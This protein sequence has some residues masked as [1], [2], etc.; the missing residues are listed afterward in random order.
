MKKRFTNILLLIMLILISL[1]FSSCSNT[2]NTKKNEVITETEEVYIEPK[3]SLKKL[4][5]DATNKSL[6]GKILFSKDSNETISLCIANLNNNSLLEISSLP[7]KEFENSSLLNL[8][9]ISPDGTKVVFTF[10]NGKDKDIFVIDTDGKNLINLSND[11]SFN[12][13][14]PEFSPD[15]KRVVFINNINN[16]REIFL[17]DTNGI[18]LINLSNSPESDDYYPMFSLDCKKLF[19]LSN[20]DGNIEIYSVNTDGATLRNLTKDQGDERFFELSP[21]GKLIAYSSVENEKVKICFINTDGSGKKII[22]DNLIECGTLTWSPNGEKLAIV[23]KIE[24]PSLGTYSDLNDIFL[25]DKDGKNFHNFTN[26]PMHKEFFGYW[27]P[28][29]SKFTFSQYESDLWV[30]SK[31]FIVDV[32]TENYKAIEFPRAWKEKGKFSLDSKK[33][34]YEICIERGTWDLCLANDEGK[35]LKRL[36]ETKPDEGLGVGN[37]EWFNNSNWVAYAYHIETIPPMPSNSK[38]FVE[39]IDS[40]EKIEIPEASEIIDVIY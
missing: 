20:R 37:Y 3:V 21:D 1:C 30:D 29:S 23:G 5:I 35:F 32:S 16:K 39:N 38:L 2:T 34:L 19:F 12:D 4:N 31:V 24:N 15:G 18:N 8:C 17:V 13:E 14:Y 36:T 6:K 7:S 40:G 28:D 9:K 33:I 10:F 26:T 11:S 22:T 25:V 27:S